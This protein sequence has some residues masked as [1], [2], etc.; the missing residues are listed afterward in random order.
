ML[1][2]LQFCGQFTVSFARREGIQGVSQSERKRWISLECL[3]LMS[4]S[5][6]LYAVYATR[7]AAENNIV[8]LFHL[9]TLKLVYGF[10]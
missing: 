7:N 8:P 1:V 6:L 3:G 10:M 9:Y 2:A 5:E 4:F